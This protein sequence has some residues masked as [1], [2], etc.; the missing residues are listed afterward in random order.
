[1]HIMTKEFV[2]YFKNKR[3]IKGRRGVGTPVYFD[4]S[5]KSEIDEVLRTKGM[6]GLN[7]AGYYYFAT[8]PANARE[9]VIISRENLSTRS[10]FNVSDIKIIKLDS[11]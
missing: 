6:L 5:T 8:G 10:G 3:D 4:S 7:E 1:M 9:N 11:T 2:Y